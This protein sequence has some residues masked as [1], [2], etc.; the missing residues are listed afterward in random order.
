MRSST[1]AEIEESV[2]AKNLP[3]AAQ[4]TIQAK[5]PKAVVSKAEK[6]TEGE[7]I[8]YEVSARRGRQRISLAFDA[9]GKLLKSSV[10]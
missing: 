2:A 7:K 3:A 5:Y 6:V 1:V 9:D 10:R 4:Q 8:K